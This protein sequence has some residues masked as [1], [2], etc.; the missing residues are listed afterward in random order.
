MDD[1]LSRYEEV[2]KHDKMIA[3]DLNSV[4]KQFKNKFF[5]LREIINEHDPV[6]LIGLGAPGNEYDP[7]VKTIIVQLDSINTVEGIQDLVYKEFRR[8]FG[9][10]VIGKKESFLE[11]AE[12]IYKWKYSN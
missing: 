5:E 2:K 8:W 4:M 10:P 12:D 1:F 6:M 9:E 7:E 3:L 11:L